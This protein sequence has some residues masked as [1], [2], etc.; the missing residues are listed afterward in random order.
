MQFQL[1][2]VEEIERAHTHT[3]ADQHRQRQHELMTSERLHLAESVY[4]YIHV[5]TCENRI[6]LQMKGDEE[7]EE[8]EEKTA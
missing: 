5:Y 3:H 8:E 1:N 6:E 7:K 4:K 2:P